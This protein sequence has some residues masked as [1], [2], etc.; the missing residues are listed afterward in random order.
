MEFREPN[1][2]DSRGLIEE[3]TS[4]SLTSFDLMLTGLSQPNSVEG[5]CRA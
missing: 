2:D 3:V 4:K 1:A 5:D